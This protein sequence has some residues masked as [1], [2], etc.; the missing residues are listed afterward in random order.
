[1]NSYNLIGKKEEKESSEEEN[2]KLQ[3]KS[4]KNREYRATIEVEEEQEVT[5]NPKFLIFLS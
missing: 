3:Q 1:M 2:K 4:Q 5:S